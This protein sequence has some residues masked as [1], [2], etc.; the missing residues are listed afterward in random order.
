MNSLNRWSAGLLWSM[1]IVSTVAA[2]TRLT[3]DGRLKRDPVFDPSGKRV[4]YAVQAAK[5]RWVLKQFKLSD[6][7]IERLH[8]LSILPEFRPLFAFDG[9]AMGF[10]QMTG[11][12]VLRLKVKIL[13]KTKPQTITIKSPRTTVWHVGLSP[14]GDQVFY[15]AAGQ[16][17]TQKVNGGREKVITK[18][19]GRN[20]WPAVSPDG[21]R[22]AF[23]SSRDGNHEIYTMKTD[24]MDVR[25][26]TKSRGLD[27]R[28][29]WSP[30]GKH[31]AF[32]SN[33][34]G[35][36]EIY[37]M[38][39]DGKNVRRLT[40]NEERD[41]YPSWHPQGKQIVFI[42]ERNGRHDVYL[43]DVRQK[44]RSAIPPEKR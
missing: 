28:P 39:V 14:R 21:K 23:G 43:L 16:I 20:N 9:S 37:R 25:R 36:Y 26:L 30:D 4:V 6:K 40:R 33:R 24:G 35:N 10:L 34:D 31:I 12:D 11:N 3:R 7:T 8:P 15:N 29:A 42:S 27:M 2:Q 18:S 38:Q 17:A 13:G 1:L 32:V 22:I 44:R 5:P 41:D 19:T